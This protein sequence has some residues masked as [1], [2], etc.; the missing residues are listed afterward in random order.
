MSYVD[1]NELAGIYM[2]YGQKSLLLTDLSEKTFQWCIFHFGI[3]WK[4]GR[5]K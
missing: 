4:T 2:L 1:L 3:H 5:I